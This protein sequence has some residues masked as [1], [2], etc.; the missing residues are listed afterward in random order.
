[1][2]TKTTW[3]SYSM[4]RPTEAL[5]PIDKNPQLDYLVIHRDR[6][7]AFKNTK[8]IYFRRGGDFTHRPERK[9][10]YHEVLT[11]PQALGVFLDVLRWPWTPSQ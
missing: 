10:E 7:K 5:L 3:V 8:H 11:N 9:V 1:M 6:R 2:M 4:I